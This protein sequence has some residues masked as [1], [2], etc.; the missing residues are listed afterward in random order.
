MASSRR[1]VRRPL[2]LMDKID[3]VLFA[4]AGLASI[5]L[6]YLLLRQGVRPGWPLLL[7]VVFWLLFTYLLLPR[8]HRV[9][10]RL[11]V[12]DY[13]IGRTRTADGLLGDPVNLAVL[14][15]EGQI[16]RAMEVAGWIR[17]DDLTAAS[18]RRM[19]GSTLT[20]RSYPHAPVSPLL[21][22]D[23]QQDFAY[24]QEVGGSTSQRHHIRFWR[25]PEGWMLPGGYS[26]DWLAAG[27]YDRSVGFSLFTFQITHKIEANTDIERDYVVST[28]TGKNPDASLQVIKDFSTGYHSRNG[29]GDLIKTDGDLPILDLRAVSA[30]IVPDEELSDSRDKRP[31]QTVFGSVVA[32]LRGVGTIVLGLLVLLAGHL[33]VATLSDDSGA[34]VTVDTIT[35]TIVGI[36]LLVGGVIDLVLGLATLRGRNIARLLVMLYCVLATIS[37]FAANASGSETIGLAELPTVALSVLVLLALSSHESREYAVRHRP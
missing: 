20:R 11:Y 34:D 24:Q 17:A 8:L 19:V 18:G 26:V 25:C 2:G 13:F 21:L 32:M 30:P 31:F 14:G 7:L 27:T 15:H 10:T 37:A 3:G 36:F 4:F 6:A 35:A 33:G 9:L 23:R 16:H 12:P 28:V 29:G 22:F 1:S 5:W